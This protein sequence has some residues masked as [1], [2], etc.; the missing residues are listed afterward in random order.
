MIPT[1]SCSMDSEEVTSKEGEH[2]AGDTSSASD[3]NSKARESYAALRNQQIRFEDALDPDGER[4]YELHKSDVVFG[5]GRGFQDHTGN[6]RMRDMIEKYKTQY[7][8]F[9]RAGKRTLVESVYKKITDGGGRFLKKLDGDYGE[10]IWVVVNHHTA[11]QKVSQY[12][13]CKRSIITLQDRD[14]QVPEAVGGPSSMPVKKNSNIAN[15]NTISNGYANPGSGV[16]SLYGTVARTSVAGLNPMNNMLLPPS[17]NT[18]LAGLEPR[19]LEA[20]D[21]YRAPSL[22]GLEPRRSAAL[23]RHRAASSY[24]MLRREQVIRETMMYQQMIDSI[25]RNPAFMGAPLPSSQ[26]LMSPSALRYGSAREST[27]KGRSDAPPAGSS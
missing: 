5:R 25:A 20:L 19:R 26:R 17:G 27:G 15:T 11:L 21:R 24:E 4:V 14:G 1:E 2:P 6:K 22:A 3:T 16:G 7:H 18:S 13:R 10:V 23:D 12:M 8:S 9:N